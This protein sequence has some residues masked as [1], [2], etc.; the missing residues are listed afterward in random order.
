MKPFWTALLVF[1]ASA[2]LAAQEPVITPDTSVDS[3][4]LHQWLHSK[5]PRLIA[6]AATF[7]RRNHDATIVAE[8]PK[9][10]ENWP[11]P[12][13][14]DDATWPAGQNRALT[15]RPVLAVLDTLIQENAHVPIPAINAIATSF[16][17][18][19]AILISR[20]P[21][22]ESRNM[23]DL[24]ML[25][26]DPISIRLSAMLFAKDPSQSAVH[27]GR[28][29]EFGFV[30]GILADAEA[31]VRITVAADSALR[32]LTGGATCGDWGGSKVAPGWPEVFAYALVENDPH[33]N[34]PLV[35]DVGGDRMATR[36]Y[37]ENS[38]GGIC[39]Y[40][41]SLN[42]RTRHRL[43]AYWLGIKPQEMAW[44]PVEPFTIRWMGNAAYQ[45]QLGKI[46]ESER[47][48][49]SATVDSLREKGVLTGPGAPPKLVVT[50]Q[51]EITPCPLH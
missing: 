25:W 33:A 12:S 38:G 8:M 48:K 39:S 20:L 10:L 44:Q 50:I 28:D 47:Q 49:L 36:R 21:L 23:L 46:L 5:N 30:A 42:A 17:T 11:M 6:W 16:P 41:E 7:A 18:Q 27:W 51:C 13:R 22:S 24:W 14:Y 32:P 4:T 26:G 45:Q 34:G 19:A 2:V 1:V 15:A 3:A 35:V 37:P 29:G 40:P 31:E 43:I 9:W